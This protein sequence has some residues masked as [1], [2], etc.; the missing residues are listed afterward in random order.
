MHFQKKFLSVCHELKSFSLIIWINFNENTFLIYLSYEI[1]NYFF[2]FALSKMLS[3]C[4]FVALL[5]NQNSE[6]ALDAIVLET[7]A[8]LALA[9]DLISLL[10]QPRM[11]S[12][13]DHDLH[14]IPLWGEQHPEKNSKIE[15]EISIIFIFL[16]FYRAQLTWCCI[17][18]TFSLSTSSISWPTSKP[19]VS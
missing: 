12:H 15:V 1:V 7:R 2:F 17:P 8:Q 6:K 19:P 10:P 9:P 4:R 14:N 5:R 18:F 3:R 13:Y 11:W 16:V